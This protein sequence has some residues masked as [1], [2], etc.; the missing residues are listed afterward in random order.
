M[1]GG[2]Y[3]HQIWLTLQLHAFCF[4]CV[5]AVKKNTLKERQCKIHASIIDIPNQNVS[6]FT[7]I[8]TRCPILIYFKRFR[9]LF[10]EGR[11]HGTSKLHLS[12]SSSMENNFTNSWIF[13]CKKISNGYRENN[14]PIFLKMFYFYFIDIVHLL[15]FYAV[16]LF[17]C[18]WIWIYVNSNYLFFSL[19]IN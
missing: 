19:L 13:T 18:F 15:I 16:F 7:S 10:F 12:K 3:N 9:F 17:P 8:L 11:L 1:L 14:H 6:S 4:K 2:H 5:K